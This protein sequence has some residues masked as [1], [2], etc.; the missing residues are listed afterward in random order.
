MERIIQVL[1]TIICALSL[2]ACSNGNHQSISPSSEIV[3]SNQDVNS[4]S[5]HDLNELELQDYFTKYIQPLCI[6]GGTW[7]SWDDAMEL[8]VEQLINFYEYNVYYEEFEEIHLPTIVAN[9]ER[10][11]MIP[12]VSIPAEE[13]ES[14]ISSYFKV[15]ES[16]LRTSECYMEA[17]NAYTFPIDFGIGGGLGLVITEV[18]DNGALRTFSCEGEGSNTLSLTVEIISDDQFTYISNTV[19]S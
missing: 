7:E 12:M 13:V 17:E 8:P 6:I 14:F 2:F 16:F 15:D 19:H 5:T 3:Q 4:N 18:I 9:P 10:Y 1:A 11:E